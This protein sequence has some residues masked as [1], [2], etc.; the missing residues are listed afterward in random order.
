MP[1]EGPFGHGAISRFSQRTRECCLWSGGGL[2]VDEERCE[3]KLKL[4]GL[5]D[6][7]CEVPRPASVF[8]MP[9]LCCLS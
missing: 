1:I 6:H 5:E 8:L 7:C 4:A 2:S 9:S 3:L